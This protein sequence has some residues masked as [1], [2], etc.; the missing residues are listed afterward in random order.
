MQVDDAT[1]VGSGCVDGRMQTEARGIHWEAAAALLHHLSQDIHLDLGQRRRETD[2]HRAGRGPHKSPCPWASTR[3]PSV[4]RHS[5]TPGARAGLGVGRKRDL[6]SAL[7]EYTGQQATWVIIIQQEKYYSRVSQTLLGIII[8]WR[9]HQNAD[10]D[11]VAKN[12]AQEST[13]LTSSQVTPRLLV[14][15]P[16]LG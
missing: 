14:Y 12:G 2:G 1:H 15:R 7:S 6:V 11:S 16:Q 10:S 9:S 8:T 4:F 3:L 13:F 5:S